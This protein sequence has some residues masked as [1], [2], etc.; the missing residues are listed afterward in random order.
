[1]N[2][3]DPIDTLKGIGDKTAL[4]LH[5]AG[6]KTVRDFF[7]NLPRSYENYQTPIKIAAIKP[8]NIV[9]RGHIS[10]LSVRRTNRKR[11]TI[12]EGIIR[13][14]S[15]AIRVVWFNQP[16]RAK[17][18]DE[19]KEYI[20]TGNYALRSGRYQLV[21]PSATLASEIR[22]D[23]GIHAVYSAHGKLK[24]MD[25][26]RLVEKSRS[27]FA[28]IPDLLPNVEPGARKNAL[29]KIHFPSSPADIQPARDYLAYEE[30]FALIL[31]GKLNK[32][33]N[34]KLKAPIIPFQ[35]DRIRA[36]INTLPFQ[37]TDAQKKAT[38]EIYQD[39]QNPVPMNRLLQ[40]DV[41]SGKTMVA[42]LA[43]F[44]VALSGRQT[45]LL[46]PTAILA[47]QHYDNLV[48]LFA[49]FGLRIALLTGATKKKG[50][51]K[52]SLKYG[53]IDLIIGTHALITDDTEFKDLALVI[54]DEQHRF[55]VEQ[56]QKLLLKSPQDTAP[57]FL[58]MTATPIPR[59][60]KL[61]IFGDLDVSILNQ[62]PAGRQ[63]IT[64]KIIAEVNL[65]TDLYPKITETIKK[66][67][68][69]YWVCQI[70]DDD[71]RQETISIK[72][73]AEKLAK[74]FPDAK[75][76]FLHGRM[77]ADE[78]DA[79]M[80]RFAAGQIDILVSTTVIEV[81][82]DVKNATLMVIEDAERFGLAALHQ[83]RGR[84]GRGD[85]K[86]SC[87]LLTANDDAPSRR[88]KELER[89][90][91]GF[92]LAEV[93]LQI[94][95]PGEI[96]GKLQHGA[97]DLQIASLTDTKLIKKAADDTEVFLQNPE[98]MLKYEELMNSIKKYQQLT[99]LN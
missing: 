9:V 56:R 96:Y 17:Q 38:W 18:F 83:L 63:P 34:Q 65:A 64:T 71:P 33:A 52:T 49:P 72:T 31:A 61:T 48:K 66:G 90:T 45:A 95:G 46:A 62:L 23:D 84:V 3:S 55:G 40:G 93:D 88:L 54:I 27:R 16:Y 5:K 6:L 70:I 85:Q 37:L 89:S 60:L 73:R 76:T 92:H 67:Q 21:S 2:L 82:V 43:A 59:S 44:A 4:I 30:L 91:D 15:D 24:S 20:F 41:G 79:I 28:E 74:V 77:K 26:R 32:K 1:M 10:D 36:L 87:F 68:Q 14:N 13:D 99:T 19:S 12:T 42:A 8:G 11:F 35:V 51:I 22:P 39:M 53:G 69:I 58:S 94:R 7:Y 29:F 86:S 81:G 25:F 57:H 47:T 98:N 97:L 75:I 78:K 50:G 80:T